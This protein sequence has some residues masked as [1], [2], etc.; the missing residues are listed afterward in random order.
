M[1]NPNTNP[2]TNPNIWDAKKQIHEKLLDAWCLVGS[3][4][5]TAE[6]VNIQQTHKDLYKAILDGYN[7]CL[8]GIARVHDR[9]D[10]S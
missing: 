3:A 4:L 1:N 7:A 8:D 2:D 5:D 6:K 9:A 10:E